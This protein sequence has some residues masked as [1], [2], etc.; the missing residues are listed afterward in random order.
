[1]GG[2]GWVVGPSM[3]V[4]VTTCAR[5]FSMLASQSSPPPCAPD[6]LCAHPCSHARASFAFCAPQES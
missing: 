3:D 4:V 2:L 6:F 1:V 5:A